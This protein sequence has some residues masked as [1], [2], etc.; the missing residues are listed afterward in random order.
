MVVYFLGGYSIYFGT[1]LAYDYEWDRY[2][3]V[4]YPGTMEYY[5]TLKR[6]YKRKYENLHKTLPNLVSVPR[7]KTMPIDRTKLYG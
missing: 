1:R 3:H 4:N 5:D 7:P 6:Y 2:F